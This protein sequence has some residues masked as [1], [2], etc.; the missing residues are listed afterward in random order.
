[1]KVTE[2]VGGGRRCYDEFRRRGTQA[3]CGTRLAQVGS[4]ACS[5]L[6]QQDSDVVWKLCLSLGL[7]Q[8]EGWEDNGEVIKLG[9]H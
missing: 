9:E 7:N 3:A 1:M 4:I 6:T 8:G 2:C 5:I